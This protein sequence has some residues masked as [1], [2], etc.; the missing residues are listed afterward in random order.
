MHQCKG[1]RGEEDNLF[2]PLKVRQLQQSCMMLSLLSGRR[3]LGVANAKL[4]I[5][6]KCHFSSFVNREYII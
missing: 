6:H 1:S 2:Y 5:S 4:K 3:Y